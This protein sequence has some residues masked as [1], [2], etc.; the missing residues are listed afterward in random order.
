MYH[1]YSK[2]LGLRQGNHI[3][4]YC[5]LLFHVLRLMNKHVTINCNHCLAQFFARRLPTPEQTTSDHIKMNAIKSP[6]GKTHL[7]HN[8]NLK[9][10]LLLD[11]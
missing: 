8:T 6:A 10:W 4:G 2:L 9:K 1:L 5:P 7:E 11:R 3:V